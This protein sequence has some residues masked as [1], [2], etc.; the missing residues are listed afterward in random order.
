MK[1]LIIFGSPRKEGNTA[2]LLSPFMDELEKLGAETELIDVYEKNI[3]GCRVCFECQK[4]ERL[5]CV[6]DDDMQPV[7]RA[8]EEADLVV[9][10][11]PVYIWSVPAPVKAVLDRL[12]YAS[13]RYYGEN[14][15]G[16]SYLKG[17]KFAVLT[18]HGYPREKATD[19]LD[20][21][22]KRFC[23]HCYAEYMGIHSERQ[24]SYKEKFMDE[25]KAMDARDFARRLVK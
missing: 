5:Y 18:T 22:M 15:S 20:E 7:Y 3:S 17:R 8:V 12:A 24:R 19:L 11:A 9:I 10:A 21:E 4:E 2:S 13:C 6:I 1:V 23:K 14:P 16:A 25:E